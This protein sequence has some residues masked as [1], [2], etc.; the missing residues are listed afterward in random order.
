[1]NLLLIL[2][3]EFIKTGF[4][5]IG[6]GYATLPFLY[7]MSIHYHWFPAIDLSQMLAI[8]SVVP[9]PIGINL[10]S[11]VGFK[12]AGLAGALVAILGILVP[13]LIFVFIISKIL[14]EFRDNRFVQ[15]ILY[16]LKPTSCGMIVAIGFK[17]LK[18]VVFRTGSTGN[19]HSIDWL[20]LGL[21]VALFAFSFKYKRSPLFYLG[22]GA[23]VGVFFHIMRSL[24]F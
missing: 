12:V 24:L 1:M 10:A 8:A 11:Q 23:L 13:S 2:F 19:F 16:V 17:L 7:D 6:G 9:G 22:A 18:D 21:F 15:S 5:A 4:F 3:L 14:K 20:A